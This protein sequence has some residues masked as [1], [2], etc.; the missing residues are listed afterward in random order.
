M[1]TDG[2]RDLPG[3][4]SSDYTDF[5]TAVSSGKDNGKQSRE[6][7]DIELAI[8]YEQDALDLERVMFLVES[9]RYGEA[10]D[11]MHDLDTAVRDQVP[12]RIYDAL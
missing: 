9:R 4:R 1:A 10:C 8:T 11:A 6:E 2:P 3:V 5:R 7:G 12:T